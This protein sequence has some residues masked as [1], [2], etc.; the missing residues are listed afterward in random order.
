M[1]GLTGSDRIPGTPSAPAP[2]GTSPA[3]GAAVPAAS[4]VEVVGA[5][6]AGASVVKE[7][8][9]AVAPAMTA[10]QPASSSSSV[11]GLGGGLL[12]W[13]HSGT[14]GGTPAAAPLMWT[15]LAFSRRELGKTAAAVTPE[16]ATSSGEPADP[17][18]GA[19][20]GAVVATPAASAVGNPI[21]DFIRIFVGDGT[22]ENPNGGILIGNGY[23][24]TAQSCPNGSCN[25]GNGGLLGNGG[26]GY[27][28]G[29]G[30]AAGW[31]GNGGAGGAAVTVTAGG[32]GGAGGLLLGSGGGGGNGS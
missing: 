24:Y 10:A 3:P 16:A 7:A 2:F 26:D 13:L 30:G 27:N 1:G 12:S 28:G 31:F 6:A 23:S 9:A 19:A 25:G 11:S 8:P 20:T 5:P 32:A 4:V 15:A 21:A 29:N 22:A 14:N 18:I 17:L